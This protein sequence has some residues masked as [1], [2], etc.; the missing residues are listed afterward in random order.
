MDGY[1]FRIDRSSVE[2]QFWWMQS[3]RCWGH[4]TSRVEGRES[5]LVAINIDWDKTR[6]RTPVGTAVAV[7][8][9]YRIADGTG[10]ADFPPSYPMTEN[11]LVAEQTVRV[12]L[13]TLHCLLVLFAAHR[14][15]P[16]TAG[17]AVL[18][19]VHRMIFDRLLS[20]NE[21]MKEQSTLQ[22][23]LVSSSE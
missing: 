16:L 3:R 6:E 17:R 21:I 4:G 15:N 23:P 1:V 8:S 12:E 5:A 7:F 14:R 11:F 2:K 20:I 18:G 9:G 22:C 10:V 13:F 19:P